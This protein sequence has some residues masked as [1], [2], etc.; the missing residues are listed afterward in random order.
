MNLF[1]R[2]GFEPTTVED[3]AH[4][5]GISRRSYFRYF[6]SKDEVFAEA[7]TSF[8]G[9]IAETLTGRPADESLWLALRHSFDPLLEQAQAV[10]DPEALGRLMLERPTLHQGKYP[11]WQSQ[12]ATARLPRLPDDGTE[13]Q[14]LRA[15]ALAAAAITCLH[16]AQ[17]QWLAPDEE[18]TLNELLDTTMGAVHPLA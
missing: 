17:T 9:T 15:E 1:L 3:I 16:V 14:S 7:L 2:Q 5:A 10:S 18:R 4:A 13:T 12:V 6:G 8:G 11:I